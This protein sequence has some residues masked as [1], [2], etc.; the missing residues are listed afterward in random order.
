MK[1]IIIL[2]INAL[3]VMLGAYLIPGI[4]VN[5]FFSAVLVAAVLG[6]LNTF[7]KPILVFLTIPISIITLGFFLLVI[8]VAI[9]K[10][11]GIIVSGFVVIGFW[12]A[13]F[14]SLFLSILSWILVKIVVGE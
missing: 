1:L 8:N 7:I 6:L 9:I 13:L 11:A 4:E 10:L 5:S 2:I 12:P 14:F 3:A